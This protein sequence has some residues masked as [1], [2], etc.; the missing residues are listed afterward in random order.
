MRMS[1]LPPLQHGEAREIRLESLLRLGE[2]GRADP[3]RGETTAGVGDLQGIVGQSMPEVHSFS[4]R[5]R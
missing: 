4:S 1:Q 3:Q 5:F 2:A